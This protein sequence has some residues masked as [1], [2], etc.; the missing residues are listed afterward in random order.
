M[1]DFEDPTGSLVSELSDQDLSGELGAQAGGWWTI[2][3]TYTIGRV[4]TLS[5]ECQGFICGWF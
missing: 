1:K 2:P 4:C 5:W 3:G